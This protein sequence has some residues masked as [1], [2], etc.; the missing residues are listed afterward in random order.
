MLGAATH[1]QPVELACCELGKRCHGQTVVQLIQRASWAAVGCPL[2]PHTPLH[3][4][5]SLYTSD[6][7]VTGLGTAPNTPEQLETPRS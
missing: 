5:A 4:K 6:M 2:L 3:L 7:L 1:R